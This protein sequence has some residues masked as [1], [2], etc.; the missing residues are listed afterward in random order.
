MLEKI[1]KNFIS[2]VL[3]ALDD[4][5]REE[6]FRGEMTWE[7]ALD[8]TNK[9]KALDDMMENL[10]MERIWRK[11]EQLNKKKWNSRNDKRIM[12]QYNSNRIV[13]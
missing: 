7:S 1:P 9:R 13:S 3:E 6:Y 10:S 2:E 8:L 12:R 5:R 11:E 4:A